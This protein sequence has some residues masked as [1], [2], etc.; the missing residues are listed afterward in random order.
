MT[1]EIALHWYAAG[2]AFMLAWMAIIDAHEARAV[3]LVMLMW[4]L[5]LVIITTMPPF[6]LLERRRSFSLR[7]PWCELQVV[8]VPQKDGGRD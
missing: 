7:C 4:P 3:A 2:A 1:I 8:K 5:F 6:V